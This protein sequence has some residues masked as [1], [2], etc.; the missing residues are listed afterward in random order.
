MADVSRHIAGISMNG[1]L[2]ISLVAVSLVVIAMAVGAYG[3]LASALTGDIHDGQPREV[4]DDLVAKHDQ[5]SVE[6]KQRFDGRSIFY[7]PPPPPPPPRPK[8][9]TPPP[10]PPV[11]V[12]TTPKVS[13]IYQG[14]SIAWVI[15]DDVYF[16]M[17]V[18]TQTEK[19]MRIRVGEERNG[20]KVV[21]TEK[22]PRTIRVA[23]GGGE[24]DVKV[25]GDNVNSAALFPTSP[26]P[27][28]LVPGFIPERS[29]IAP[30]ATSTIAADAPAGGAELNQQSPTSD[31]AAAPPTEDAA[32]ADSDA[33]RDAGSRTRP[34]GRTRGGRGG[35]RPQRGDG[36]PPRPEGG[37]PQPAEPTPDDGEG[38]NHLRSN[39]R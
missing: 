8:V 23:H 5:K 4:I 22:M 24:Y 15:G 19:Y 18:P 3:V 1:P 13:P 12:D 6:N 25:F 2:A 10:P 29:A 38:G 31:I 34:E 16:N 37:S 32:A 26:K 17:T 9:D 33:R 7:K 28:I 27:S 21:S 20:V 39:A 11:P 35:G 36:D 14:P 30:A